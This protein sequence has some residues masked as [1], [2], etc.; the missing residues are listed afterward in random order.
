[1]MKQLEQLTMLATTKKA[2]QE[3]L[4]ELD[5]YARLNSE[6]S[7]C[8]PCYMAWKQMLTDQNQLDFDTMISKATQ[9]V[10]R[11]KFKSPWRFI[12]VDEYQDISPAR[13]DL[14]SALCEKKKG[15]PKI[16]SNLF[17]VGDD[18]Q[19]IYQFSGADVGLTTRFVERFPHSTITELDTTYRFNNKIGEVANRFIQQNPN[20]LAK[21]LKSHVE[22][23]RN[24]V[25]VAPQNRV[26][27]ILDQLNRSASEPKSVLLLARKNSN[28]PELL[29]DWED[30]F[31]NLYIK[32]MTCHSSKGK[33]A[34]FVIILNVDEGQFPLKR[35]FHHLDSALAS[36]GGDNYPDAEERRL[37]YVAL[38]RAKEKVWATYTAGGSTFIKELLS[39]DYHVSKWK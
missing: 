30:S 36:Q 24:T 18:W 32:F 5:D 13:L 8:W 25:F 12:M 10:V 20:Q 9:Y 7:L 6:L 3:K 33:E 34:D 14:I 26:E 22:R 16:T 28:K 29:P 11:G 27:K 37:F 17:A 15:D 1:L 35:K 2:L 38:T 39:G 23:K 19:S 31:R 4:V 21:T